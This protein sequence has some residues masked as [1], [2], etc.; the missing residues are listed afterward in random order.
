MFVFR[1]PKS[2]FQ[3]CI[4][5]QVKESDFAIVAKLALVAFRLPRSLIKRKGGGGGGG[6][7]IF[8]H[9]SKSPPP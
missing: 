1:L 6:V 5:L 3:N 2:I 9:F 4:I 8:G 7:L